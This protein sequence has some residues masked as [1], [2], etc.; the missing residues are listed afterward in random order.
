VP[1]LSEEAEQGAER[2]DGKPLLAPHGPPDTLQPF[3]PLR[4]RVGGKLD[5]VDGPHRRSDHEVGV[6]AA[7][8]QRPQHADFY[9]AETAATCENERRSHRSPPAREVAGALDSSRLFPRRSG[10]GGDHRAYPVAYAVGCSALL[11]EPQHAA[12]PPP[13]AVPPSLT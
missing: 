11:L 3:D 5:G 6:D 8:H 10:Y 12:P 13:P 9:R 7:L 4:R 1:T 2:G